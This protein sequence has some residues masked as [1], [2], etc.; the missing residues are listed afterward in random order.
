[1][2]AV[3][4]WDLVLLVAAAYVAVTSLARLMQRH[5][6]TVVA[7]LQQQVELERRRQATDKKK[8]ENER[9]NAGRTKRA[10]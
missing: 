10:A 9:T 3:S 8:A 6:D 4:S 7:E 1:M 5:R 2:N